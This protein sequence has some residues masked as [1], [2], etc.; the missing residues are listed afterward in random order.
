LRLK[1]LLNYQ[2]KNEVSWADIN[3]LQRNVWF[4]AIYA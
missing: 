1:I 4:A 3:K 2:L